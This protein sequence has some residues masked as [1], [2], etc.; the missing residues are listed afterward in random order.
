M[1]HR[2]RRCPHSSLQGAH[3][4]HTDRAWYYQAFPLCPI[5]PK[6]T[7]HS[8]RSLNKRGL[9]HQENGVLALTG[10]TKPWGF[11]SKSVQRH[12]RVAE[13]RMR[14]R[15]FRRERKQT[16]TPQSTPVRWP[17]PPSPPLGKAP[18]RMFCRGTKYTTFTS[19]QMSPNSDW[20][21]GQRKKLSWTAFIALYYPGV[22]Q[23]CVPEARYFYF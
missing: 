12:T 16:Q 7:T 21:L 18:P 4:S 11:M 17:C 9:T 19:F 14:G 5:C 22:T 20:A 3:D 23:L 2:T 1:F 8:Y 6:S 15:H 13:A 10:M